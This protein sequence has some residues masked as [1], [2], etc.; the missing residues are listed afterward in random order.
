[1]PNG[2]SIAF[3]LESDNKKYIFLGDAHPSVVIDSLKSIGTTKSN[4]L[5]VELLKV[6]H[7]SSSYNTNEELLSLG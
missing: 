7:H 1:M 3:I 2:S 6:S 4:P 5:E